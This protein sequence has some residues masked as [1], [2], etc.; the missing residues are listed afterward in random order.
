MGYKKRSKQGEVIKNHLK[1]FVA[2]LFFALILLVVGIVSDLFPKEVDDYVENSL[3]IPINETN[4][5]DVST[6]DSTV[7]TS[8]ADMKIYYF[9]VG[10]ADSEL[11]IADNQ[12]MLIDAGNKD[13]GKNLV[14][15]IKALG[16]KKIDYLVGTHAHED[17]IGG[18]Q[19]VVESFNIGSVYMPEITT[20]T[21]T[22]ENLLLAISKKG[23]GISTCNIGDQITLGSGIFTVMNV[24]NDDVEDLNDSSICLHFVYGQNKYLF[25]GDASQRMEAEVNWPEV[26]ILKVAHHGSETSSS[27]SFLAQTKPKVAIISCG[28]NNSYGHPTEEVLTRLAKIGTEIYRT[29]EQGTILVTS[30]GSKYDITTIKTSIDGNK[31]TS[32]NTKK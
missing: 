13:D 29:D 22:Y 27:D 6:V 17:H 7:V 28:K 10:Q 25:M 18:M 9:D 21:R 14:K 2:T 12:V 8:D 31:T 20:T 19:K 16:V 32:T 5:I 11:I 3:N 15:Y 26:D 23:L 4:A 1:K 24:H 30:N